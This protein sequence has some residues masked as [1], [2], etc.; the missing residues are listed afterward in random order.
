MRQGDMHGFRHTCTGTRGCQYGHEALSGG[1]P[2]FRGCCQFKT[3]PDAKCPALTPPP[4]RA[5]IHET[6]RV[7]MVGIVSVI[8]LGFLCWVTGHGFLII[9]VIC[10]VKRLHAKSTSGC[11]RELV[12]IIIIVICVVKRHLRYL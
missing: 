4:L 2:P 12:Q 1:V 8:S 11:V 9:I 7:R 6:G 10:V 3:F 5:R